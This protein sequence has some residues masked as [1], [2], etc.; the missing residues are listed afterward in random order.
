ALE[1]AYRHQDRFALPVWWR[2][3]LREQEWAGALTSLALGLEAQLHD[4]GVTM[5][6]KITTVEGVRRFLPRLTEGLEQPG[7]LLVLDNM[8]TLLTADGEW[9]DPRWAQLITALT[10][11]GGESR[12]VLTS[13]IRPTGLDGRV[14]VQ[15]VHALS[16]AESALLARELPHLR[17]LLH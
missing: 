4:Y 5:V 9:R 3:P 8:E 10:A 17:R 13:R 7:L 12:V 14:V 6:D 15:A 1:L 2:A 11:H 16:L